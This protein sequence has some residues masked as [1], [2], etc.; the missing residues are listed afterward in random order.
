MIL[1]LNICSESRQVALGIYKQGNLKFVKD[2]SGDFGAARITV[3]RQRDK[4]LLAS[5]DLSY[6]SG[7]LVT[8]I[9]HLALVH[10]KDLQ[11]VFA[12][13]LDDVTKA[14]PQLQSLEIVIGHTVFPESFKQELRS[15]EVNH[16]FH[17]LVDRTLWEFHPPSRSSS[18]V[19]LRNTAMQL[20]EA[21]WCWKKTEEQ[22]RNDWFHLEFR[23]RVLVAQKKNEEKFD[24]LWFIRCLRA[25]TFQG[26]Q[27]AKVI[28][29]NKWLSVPVGY[30]S[31][32]HGKLILLGQ[33]EDETSKTKT[34]STRSKAR[35]GRRR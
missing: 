16:D 1:A 14:C 34:K 19:Y 12:G 31:A 30:Q 18:A 11:P 21:F 20:E 26:A 35:N 2:E 22:K 6:L 8:S 27:E 25:G 15:I 24:G 5:M 29:P 10:S 23:V 28:A 32:Y 9:V 4:F 7:K 33:E 13:K 3:D 17:K